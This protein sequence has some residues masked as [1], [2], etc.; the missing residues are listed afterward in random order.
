LT[1][2]PYLWFN[3]QWKNIPKLE[4]R[5]LIFSYTTRF[6]VYS[7]LGKI[8]S[9]NKKFQK[10]ISNID[11]V[12]SNIKDFYVSIVNLLI[13]E[14]NRGIDFQK[15]LELI[16]K[17]KSSNSMQMNKD[18][19]KTLE[20][21]V[22]HF[23]VYYADVISLSNIKEGKKLHCAS[24]M[25]QF[26]MR[27]LYKAEKVLPFNDKL[28]E[29]IDSIF[30]SSFKLDHVI[31]LAKRFSNIILPK[32]F[33]K[34]YDELQI[35]EENLNFQCLFSSSAVRESERIDSIWSRFQKLESIIFE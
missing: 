33:H 3:L 2:S 16:T 8:S 14:E 27:I 9:L 7:F 12:N 18:L 17:V 20:E 35:F 5:G 31:D 21:L 26:L 30:P 13:R 11:S 34:L 1:K 25:Q 23:E 28:L 19:A 15:K 6:T 24:S 4:I 32:N 29:L 10:K 22:S